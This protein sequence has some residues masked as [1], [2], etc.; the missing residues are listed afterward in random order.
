MAKTPAAAP[1]EGGERVEAAETAVENAV[2]AVETAEENP[3]DEAAEEAA[4][5]AM[6]DAV[7][8]VKGID[9]WLTTNREKLEKAGDATPGLQTQLGTLQETLNSLSRRLDKLEKEPTKSIQ[10]TQDP[11]PNQDPPIRDQSGEGARPAPKTE[12]AE[13]KFRVI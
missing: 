5:D 9:Q 13:K 2:E 10:P 12:R 8:K 6:A 4:A 1:A 3:G 7:K 11:P